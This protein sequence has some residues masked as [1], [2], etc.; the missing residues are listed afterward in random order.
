[1]TQTCL[2]LRLQPW[3]KGEA[4]QPLQS[5]LF[6]E[7]KTVVIPPHKT[8]MDSLPNYAGNETVCQKNVPTWMYLLNRASGFGPPTRVAC[9][10]LGGIGQGESAKNRGSMAKQERKT[11]RTTSID[12]EGREYRRRLS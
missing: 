8:W 7:T 10:Y 4:A 5:V 9:T 6:P 12:V 3:A 1:M 11:V 2:G